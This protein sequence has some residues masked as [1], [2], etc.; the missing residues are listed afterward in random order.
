MLKNFHLDEENQPK[1]SLNNDQPEEKIIQLRRSDRK[2]RA[3]KLAAKI[4]Q[5]DPRKKMP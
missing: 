5:Y 3:A 1:I 4:I 2:R